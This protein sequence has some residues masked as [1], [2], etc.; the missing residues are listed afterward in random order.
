HPTIHPPPL[1]PPFPYTT[2]F[3]S[4]L[5]ARHRSTDDRPLQRPDPWRVQRRVTHA[6]ARLALA[7]APVAII[8]GQGASFRT[9]QT[10]RENGRRKDRKSTRLNSSHVSISY[11]VFC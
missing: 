3:R 11:A 10:S 1:P 5:A 8:T 6:T 7:E 2:L 4:D 9:D